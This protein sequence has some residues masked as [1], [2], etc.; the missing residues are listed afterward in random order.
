MSVI[1]KFECQSCHKKRTYKP[2]YLDTRRVVC[3]ACRRDYPT[4]A[5]RLLEEWSRYG[6]VEPLALSALESRLDA[7]RA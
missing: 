5:A 4:T 2:K 7:A 3:M 6:K 1:A